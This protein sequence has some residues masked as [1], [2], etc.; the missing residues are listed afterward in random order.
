ML[1]RHQ[2]VVPPYT[3]VIKSHVCH[4]QV[5]GNLD[6][7][8]AGVSSTVGQAV[9]QLTDT[10]AAFTTAVG[11][12]I[13]SGQAAVQQTLDSVNAQVTTV[14]TQV[15]GNRVCKVCIALQPLQAQRGG[16]VLACCEW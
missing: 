13:S 15:C 8:T 3:H 9:T 14:A 5:K 1:R 2:V 6:Q 10:T 12:Q 16:C 7:A 11:E 4:L